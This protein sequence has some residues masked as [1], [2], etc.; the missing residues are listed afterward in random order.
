MHSA[1]NDSAYYKSD[2]HEVEIS[3]SSKQVEAS[4][5]T[6][7]DTHIVDRV[8]KLLGVSVNPAVTG[9]EIIEQGRCDITQGMINGGNRNNQQQRRHG[10]LD[11]F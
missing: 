3:H 4:K 7:T 5:K 10:C 11:G 1:I 9:V 8:R 6:I 2:E